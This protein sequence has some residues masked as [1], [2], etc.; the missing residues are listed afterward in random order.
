[1]RSNEQRINILIG[2]LEGVKKMLQKKNNSCLDSVTQLKAVRSSVA[3]L[4]DKILEEEF[5]TCF[6]KEFSNDKEKIKKIFSEVLK[7]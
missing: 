4:M 5:E 6:S 3:S 1:M 7:K 2:Q